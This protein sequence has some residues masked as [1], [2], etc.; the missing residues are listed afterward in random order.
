MLIL[1]LNIV[2]LL[3]DDLGWAATLVVTGSTV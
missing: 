1:P 2:L 3:V